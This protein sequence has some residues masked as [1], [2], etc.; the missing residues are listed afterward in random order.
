M[1]LVLWGA[2]RM[3]YNRAFPITIWVGAL[4]VWTVVVLGSSAVGRP[5]A[6]L[7][8]RVCRWLFRGAGVALVAVIAR[9]LSGQL[10]WARAAAIGIV[11]GLSLASIRGLLL[12]AVGRDRVGSAEGFRWALLQALAAYAFHSYVLCVHIGAGDA[13]HY[14]LSMGDFIRQV[15]AGIFPVFIGQSEFAFNGGIHTVR[16]APY[17]VHLG[18]LLDALTLHTLPFYAVAN[19]TIVLSASLGVLGTYAALSLYAPGRPMAAAAL[20]ALYMLSPRSWPLYEGDMIATFMTVPMI[21]WWVLGLALAA[22]DEAAWRPWLMQGAALA[23]MWWAH[24]RLRSGRP[25]SPWSPGPSSLRATATCGPAPSE[26]PLP[27]C[28]SPFL[29]DMNSCR[30]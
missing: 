4:L 30:S 3:Y 27:F 11:L 10:G 21:P 1:G 29:R 23:A 20:A 12:I 14:S 19:L 26:C 6:G 7:A 13:Y 5:A 28:C 24:P 17:F 18:A 15:R 25:Q 22:E 9:A 2:S 8:G 16:T